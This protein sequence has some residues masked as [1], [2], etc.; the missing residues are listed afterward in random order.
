[1]NDLSSTPPTV[2]QMNA[3]PDSNHQEQ[4]PGGTSTQKGPGI[5]DAAVLLTLGSALLYALGWTYWTSFLGYYGLSMQFVEL[6]FDRVL[7][8]TWFIGFALI[9]QVFQ[10]LALSGKQAN[11]ARLS[12]SAQSVTMLTGCLLLGVGW[13]LT[14]IWWHRA[15]LMLGCLALVGLSF[16]IEKRFELGRWLVGSDKDIRL[17]IVAV[18]VVFSLLVCGYWGMGY[19][20]AKFYADGKGGTTMTL[21][22]EGEWQPPP[23]LILLV[24]SSG[25]LAFVDPH[26]WPKSGAVIPCPKA[27]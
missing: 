17:V 27:S 24:R 20:H 25:M 12:V 18:L 10:V 11:L 22:L 3:T 26:V 13:A 6:T 15:L 1:M 7:S 4:S 14:P 5:L 8:T 2:R 9:T 16:G 19:M 23:G 21:R